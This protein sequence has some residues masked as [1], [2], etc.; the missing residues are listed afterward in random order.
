MEDIP[1]DNW[2][3]KQFIAHLQD[4][5]LANTPNEFDGSHYGKLFKELPKQSSPFLRENFMPGGPSFGVFETGG[6]QLS[7]DAKIQ[8]L[9]ENFGVDQPKPWDYNPGKPRGVYYPK[10][11][12][13]GDEQ[14]TMSH[15]FDPVR[16]G[17]LFTAQQ[18]HLDS[19]KNSLGGLVLRRFEAKK[20]PQ[21]PA[22]LWDWES[23]IP[24]AQEQVERWQKAVEETQKR[25]EL[26][27]GFQRRQSLIADLRDADPR[28][29]AL[30]GEL[31][32]VFARGWVKAKELGPFGEP[33]DP[34]KSVKEGTAGGRALVRWFR[35]NGEGV[36]GV[37]D[38]ELGR[39]GLNSREW[40]GKGGY[41]LGLS[42]NLA[43]LASP[44]FDV[45]RYMK[46]GFDEKTGQTYY[47]SEVTEVDGVNFSNEYLEA[48]SRMHPR[49]AAKHPEI[50]DS[51]RYKFHPG[52]FDE[53]PAITTKKRDDK[54]RK[55]T[56]AP[57]AVPM[58]T[59]SPARKVSINIDT[60][61][62]IGSFLFS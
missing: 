3:I 60:N 31:E 29:N 38:E 12:F 52:W 48:V 11:Y 20:N 1:K 50:T 2:D 44:G 33:L 57:K 56:G 59:P 47:P 7:D 32:D 46:G 13:I 34:I 14:V 62:D 37:L 15:L 9:Q 4:R 35:N 40:L 6:R 24:K 18:K 58:E 55:E 23:Y 42:G 51:Q 45:H 49:N 54:F 21:G 19:S 26:K 16:E 10:R 25:L 22:A 28:I 61:S 8:F 5:Y 43:G 27:A 53:D 17:E 30:A 39:H 36:A 41:V